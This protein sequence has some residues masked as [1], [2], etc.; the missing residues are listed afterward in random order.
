[1]FESVNPALFNDY[2]EALHRLNV[3]KGERM[4]LWQRTLADEAPET[5]ALLKEADAKIAELEAEHERLMIAAGTG[6]R[7]LG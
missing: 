6:P 1:M 7:R 3:A 5:M 2:Y 4:K